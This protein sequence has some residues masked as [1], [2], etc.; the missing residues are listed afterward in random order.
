VEA[1]EYGDG[2][3][4]AIAATVAGRAGRDPL[5]DALMGARLV[6][7]ED[8]SPDDIFELL[9]VADEHMVEGLPAQA[10]DESLSDRFH[11]RG[12]YCCLDH[13]RPDALGDAIERGSELLVPVSDQEPGRRALR[14]RVSQLLSGP[15][16]RGVPRGR[17]MDDST[18]S[19]VHQ[20]EEEQRPEEQV[21]SLHEVA[22][23]DVVGVV[24]DEGRPRLAATAT[25]ANGAHVLLHGPLTD[26]DAQLQELAP[27]PFGTPQ[28]VLGSHVPDQGDGLGGDPMFGVLGPRSATP[29]DAKPLAVPAQDRLRLD[30]G[31]GAAPCRKHRS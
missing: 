28:P 5:S 17:D 2:D 10:T 29:E 18:R 8:V 6:E 22:A 15:L 23:P 25:L 31:Q 4:P 30:D 3:D 21:V 7:I 19:L 16:L 24:L 12:S 11:V 26:R 1:A 13:L 27:N 9:L 20:E 14:G